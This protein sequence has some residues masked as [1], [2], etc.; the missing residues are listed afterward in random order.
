MSYTFLLHQTTTSD[1]GTNESLRL[2]YTFLL[3]QTTTSFRRFLCFLPIVLYLSSTSNHNTHM[4]PLSFLQLSY[5]FLLHQT[6]TNTE[7]G[8]LM[9]LL[10]YT[11]LLHQTTT[12]NDCMPTLVKLS[13]TF[14]LHQ[15]TTFLLCSRRPFILSYTFLLHQTTTY[16]RRMLGGACIVLYLSSTSNHNAF[17]RCKQYN[18]LSYTFLLHQTTTKSS[19]TR[20]PRYCLIP[21]FYI[22]PQRSNPY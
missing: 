12:D 15:T 10:S 16:R 18:Q 3:H 2:S 14:L 8:I 6:T 17:F 11:F 7:P 21:F 4:Q 22:K 13:Y 9:F 5:T 19:W 20:L 1:V